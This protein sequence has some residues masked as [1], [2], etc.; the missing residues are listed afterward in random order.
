MGA[1]CPAL[2]TVR[3]SSMGSVTPYT[4][5]TSWSSSNRSKNRSSRLIT[6]RGS[7]ST[8]TGPA[9]PG[10]AQRVEP[11]PFK[12]PVEPTHPP[13]RVRAHRDEGAD[14]RTDLR[15]GGRRVQPAPH[16]VADKQRD[17]PFVQRHHVVEVPPRL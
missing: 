8:A 4:S 9:A 10:R 7:G 12:D 5:V 17:P 1:G 15:H 6:R 14:R 16:H 3:L 13:A 11:N 2:T